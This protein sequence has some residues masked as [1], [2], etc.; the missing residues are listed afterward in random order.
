MT[1]ATKLT[2]QITLAGLR[3]QAERL[4]IPDFAKMRKSQLIK[5]ISD[6]LA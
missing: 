4:E 3:Q 1:T 2:E 5:A 6:A